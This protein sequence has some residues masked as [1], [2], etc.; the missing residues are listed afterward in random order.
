M[1]KDV[2]IDP[3]VSF[4]FIVRRS[5]PWLTILVV[6]VAVNLLIW[7]IGV[8]PAR[9]ELTAAQELTSLVQ[10]KPQLETLIAQSDRLLLDREHEAYITED[11]AS[12]EKWIRTLAK[13]KGVK[14][15]EVNNKEP[16]SPSAALIPVELKVTGGYFRLTHWLNAMEEN[17]NI[18][19]DHFLLGPSS[20]PGADNQ[21]DIT[22]RVL[23]KN[24]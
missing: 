3:T 13:T 18:Q 1:T 10:I 23:S 5:T 14:I 6:P 15:E 9:A 21:L 4:W 17:P 19:M 20:A 7:K 24:P 12:A 11:T 16:E 22:V 2:T 8:I